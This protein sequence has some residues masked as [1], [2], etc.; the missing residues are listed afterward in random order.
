MSDDGLDDRGNTVRKEVAH[1][2]VR[3][4]PPTERPADEGRQAKKH[5]LSELV[6]KLRKSDP[7]FDDRFRKLLND[8]VADASKSFDVRWKAEGPQY[9]AALTVRK[10]DDDSAIP[11]SDVDLH[12]AEP[13]VEQAQSVSP[14]TADA[15]VETPP[16]VPATPPRASILPLSLMMAGVAAVIVAANAFFVI[17]WMPAASATAVTDVKQPAVDGEGLAGSGSKVQGD[18]KSTSASDPKLNAITLPKES[19]S[20]L[21]AEVGVEVRK[22]LKEQ[23]VPK[24]ETGAATASRPWTQE[25]LDALAKNVAGRVELPETLAS[26]I[27]GKVKIPEAS[28]GKDEPRASEAKPAAAPAKVPTAKEIA[29]QLKT[30]LGTELGDFNKRAAGLEAALKNSGGATATRRTGDIWIVGLHTNA[31][32]QSQYKPAIRDVL[33][34]GPRGPT[35][36]VRLGYMFAETTQI[37]PVVRPDAVQA[38]L[39]SVAKAS[40]DTQEFP[41]GFGVDLD[42][43]FDRKQP[44]QCA[45]LIA[46]PSCPALRP[47]HPGWEVIPEV[48]VVLVAEAD[49][50]GEQK[51]RLADWHRFVQSRKGTLRIVFPEPNLSRQN[52]ILKRELQKVCDQAL[53]GQ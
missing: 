34:S 10:A 44:R 17:R 18:G 43:Q 42:R 22:A 46:S 2:P 50:N 25:E 11:E 33:T 40:P 7:D 38:D 20:E 30:T 4:A 21:V 19:R 28:K 37:T 24:A 31:L 13:P 36:P 1:T 6:G 51:S 41:E 12:E 52:E 49:L 9:I 16:V 27:A 14:Q 32:D 8:E 47:D 39:A 5:P 35:A 48:H 26:D 53:Q 45:V 3:K 29:D 23:P 15:T